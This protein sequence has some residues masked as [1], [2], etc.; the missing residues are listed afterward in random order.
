[1]NPLQQLHLAQTRRQFFGR[2]AAGIGTAALASLLNPQLFA[3]TT[4]DVAG[5]PGALSQLHFPAKAKRVIY[6]FMSGGPSHIDLFD[7]KP[8]LKELNGTDL[9]AEIRMGQRI[10]GMTAGQKSFPCAAPIFQFA[11]HGESGAWVSELLP[12]IAKITDRIAIVKSMHTEA[13]NHDP[14]ITFI[15]TGSQQPGRPS[16]GAWLSYGLGADS[17]NLPAFIVMISQGSG[18]KTDQP[19]FSRLWGSGFIPSQHQGVRFRSGDDP[20]L[21]LSNPPGI[22][23]ESRRR[24]LDG[25]GQLNGLAAESVGDPEINTRIAQYEMAYRMQTSVPDLTDLS[26]EPQH[27]IDMYGIKDDGVDGGFAR[28]CLLAR[29][30]AERGVRFIQL[31][32]R[33]WDQ[34]GSLPMQIRGQCKDVDQPSAALIEDLAQRGLLDETLV[35]WGGEFGRTVYSQ[36]ALTADN[37]GRDHHGRCFSMWLAGG[38][39][40]P[41]V[42][43]GETDDYCYNIVK[44]PVH[45]HDLNATALNCL[46][47]DHTRLIYRF[48]GRDYRLTDVHGELVPGILA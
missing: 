42:T 47:I 28:N 24:M 30:M 12:N 34:H 26:D 5:A 16:F 40:K 22:D 27:V 4:G 35:I 20:V 38:G 33:G 37:Y 7:Y 23:A 32:H 11:Q 3:G 10:T 36:G 17:A 2:A 8:K 45:I 39:I 6:L 43:W 44:D 46:G 15:Q 21:Y 25:I 19:I 41:G 14:A 31:M 18:N 48:Q 1:M 13:I 9:P 29:R